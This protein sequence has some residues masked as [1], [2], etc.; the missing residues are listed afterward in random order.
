M[1]Q[2]VI[3]AGVAIDVNT[4]GGRKEF[5]PCVLR[6]LTLEVRGYACFYVLDLTEAA[7]PP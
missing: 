4:L 3:T 7:A 2:Q 5:L 6:H 1:F